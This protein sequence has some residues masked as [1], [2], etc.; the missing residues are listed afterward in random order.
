LSFIADGLGCQELDA[1][2]VVS[3]RTVQVIGICSLCAAFTLNYLWVE[4]GRR[5][6]EQLLRADLSQGVYVALLKWFAP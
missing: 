4:S 6:E 3:K 5:R 1:V 2:E